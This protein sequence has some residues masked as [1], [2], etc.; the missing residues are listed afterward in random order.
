MLH[1]LL[2]GAG[3]QIG[4]ILNNV[5]Q[6]AITPVFSA[7]PVIKS[8]KVKV[9]AVT[10]ARRTSAVAPRDTCAPTPAPLLDEEGWPRSG[11]GGATT[12][13]TPAEDV[14]RLSAEIRKVLARAEIKDALAK[15]GAEPASDTP[16]EFAAIVRADVDK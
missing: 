16:E 4:A 7:L 11:G 1:V 10:S 15:Q 5:V 2:K 13:G 8:G 3:P 6:V 9:L 14:S 12:A